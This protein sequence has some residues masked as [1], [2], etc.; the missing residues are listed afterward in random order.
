VIVWNDLQGPQEAN[1]RRNAPRLKDP[2]RCGRWLSPNI[3]TL[4]LN[5]RRLVLRSG[6]RIEFDADLSELEDLTW[7][8]SWLSAAFETM[9]RGKRYF[10]SFLG[11]GGILEAWWSGIHTGRRWRAEMTRRLGGR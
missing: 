11:R 2:I 5:G 1:S 9:V 7:H 3:G 4:T 6:G 10:F 8:W